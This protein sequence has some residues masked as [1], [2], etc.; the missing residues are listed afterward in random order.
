M[1][2][3]H[4]IK[5][6]GNRARG[7]RAPLAPHAL[8]VQGH[9]L[10]HS[11][12]QRLAPGRWRQSPRQHGARHLLPAGCV[13][14]GRL[15]WPTWSGPRDGGLQRV[16][17]ARAY[18]IASTWAARCGGRQ[19]LMAQAGAGA[20]ALS[21]NQQGRIGVQ[22]VPVPQGRWPVSTGHPTPPVGGECTARLRGER[23]EHIPHTVVDPGVADAGPRVH[24]AAAH[25]RE[26][27]LRVDPPS[28]N[29]D[30]PSD[31]S[32]PTLEQL[33]T[34]TPLGQLGHDPPSDNSYN[35][36]WTQPTQGVHRTRGERSQKK[37]RSARWPSARRNGTGHG[38]LMHPGRGAWRPVP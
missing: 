21:G 8:D 22:G 35:S 20:Q 32:R 27:T 33:P 6:M 16:V 24:A 7:V 4:R 15:V 5:A 1:H 13:Q 37:W 25:T 19:A 17:E 38:T 18:R 23:S 9:R 12:D 3:D 31:N 2:P 14:A 28:D 11:V 29:S 26:P 30:P 36:P 34:R 10:G